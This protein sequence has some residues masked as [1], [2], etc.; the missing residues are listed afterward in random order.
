MSY[1]FRLAARDLLYASSHRQISTYHGLCYIICCGRLAGTRNNS[2]CKSQI[3]FRIE[4]SII[5]EWNRISNI[6]R[7]KNTQASHSIQLPKFEPR[8]LLVI[9]IPILYKVYRGI[10]YSFGCRTSEAND[11]NYRIFHDT[12]QKIPSHSSQNTVLKYYAMYK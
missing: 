6:S 1:Y 12:F 2:I 4:Y 9:V 8:R 10:S 7:K 5:Y 11:Q 3:S